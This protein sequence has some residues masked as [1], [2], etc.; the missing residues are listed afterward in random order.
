MIR[1][2]VY[3]TQKFGTI[4]NQEDHPSPRELVG[5]DYHEGD[6]LV[7]Q[8]LPD[9]LL[10]GCLLL[11]TGRFGGTD[12]KAAGSRG[13]LDVVPQ[14]MEPFPRSPELPYVDVLLTK[15]VQSIPQRLELVC[16]NFQEPPF[17]LGQHERQGVRNRAWVPPPKM[18]YGEFNSGPTGILAAV[19]G[20]EFSQSQ[21]AIPDL[22]S[23]R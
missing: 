11:T 20:R 14:I 13:H 10:H 19:A 5:I 1:S 18:F 7:P 15:E 6:L 2:P 23:G 9:G 22:G 3:K 17:V 21:K 16:P 8:S 4:A 12:T